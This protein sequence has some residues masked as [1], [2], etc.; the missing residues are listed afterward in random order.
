MSERIRIPGPSAHLDFLIIGAMKAGSISLLEFLAAHPSVFVPQNREPHYFSMRY[1]YSSF[2]YR[3]LFRARRPQ[4]I[5]G[6]ASTSYSDVNE[7]PQCPE[8]IANDAPNARI[9]YVIRDPVE[10]ILSN[11]RYLRLRGHE[12]NIDS[13]VVT[14]NEL[15][16]KSRYRNTIDAYLDF[17]PR[18]RLFVADL[19]E[20]NKDE[21]WLRRILSFLKLDPNPYDKLAL[22]Q[23]NISFQRDIESLLVRGT[24]RTPL[25]RPLKDALPDETIQQL[26][27]FA[28]PSKQLDDIEIPGISAEVLRKRFPDLCNELDSQYQWAR[29]HFIDLPED[30]VTGNSQPAEPEPED[31]RPLSMQTDV[32]PEAK[33]MEPA[34]LET[35]PAVTSTGVTT[36]PVTEAESVPRSAEP[37]QPTVVTEPEAEAEAEAEI[38]EPREAANAR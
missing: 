38:I 21:V 32:K 15:W 2:Y 12:I 27:T 5:C 26:K 34:A 10:R 36:D 9:I 6:E 25:G 20:L 13:K 8:R 14:D 19:H 18:S 24:K 23:A 16:N 33:P 4:Q 1:H 3:W 28:S 29:T 7:F 22:P 11:L 35:A 17:F 37:T 30:P 31:F